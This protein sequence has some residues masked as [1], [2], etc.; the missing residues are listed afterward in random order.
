[1]SN[2]HATNAK[3][4]II[5]Y[6]ILWY[7]KVCALPSAHSSLVHFDQQNIQKYKFSKRRKWL[8]ERVEAEAIKLISALTYNFMKKLISDNHIYIPTYIHK[9]IYIYTCTYIYIHIHIHTYIQIHT[10]IHKYIHTH[11]HTYL[12]K[13]KQKL[14]PL[15]YLWCFINAHPKIFISD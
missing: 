2:W 1:V 11:T 4:F 5:Q 6:A 10:H 14:S 3:M 12:Q 8:T 7:A 9:H 15:R 13:T